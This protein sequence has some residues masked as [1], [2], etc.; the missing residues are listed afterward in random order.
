MDRIRLLIMGHRTFLTSISSQP[1]PSVPDVGQGFDDMDCTGGV[2]VVFWRTSCET[3]A[4]HRNPLFQ[5][6]YG[7]TPRRSICVDI[8]HCLYLGV[9][10]GLC[11]A[12]VW[13]LIKNGRWGGNQATQHEGLLVACASI[14]SELR[15][16][17]KQR[18]RLHPT[19]DLTRI[20]SFS[21]RLVG[22]RAEPVL[23]TK[24][25]ETYGFMLFL[26]DAM[27]PFPNRFGT[28]GR[29]FLEAMLSL[30]KMIQ[31]WK[32]CHRVMSRCDIEDLFLVALG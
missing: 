22:T 13:H 12:T 6:R 27:K 20:A 17:Y 26:T 14:K 30:E 4:R 29:A 3:I 5:R 1:S 24:G 21:H 18:R 8:L 16:W 32:R 19:E 7:V 11:R 10:L 2:E 9:M 31:I 15:H 25:A 28:E 23:K